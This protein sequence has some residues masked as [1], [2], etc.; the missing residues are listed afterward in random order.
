MIRDMTPQGLSVCDPT[1]IMSPLESSH[2]RVAL[3]VPTF[4]AGATWPAFTQA[5]QGQVGVDMTVWVVDSNSKDGTLGQAQSCAW[6]TLSLGERAFNHGGTRQWAIERIEADVEFVVLMTQDALLA[7]P[8][9]L[10]RLLKPFAN[11]SVGAVYGRQLPHADATLLAAQARFFNYPNSSF[12]NTFEDR[13]RLGLKAAF[14]SNSF[15]AYR[16]THFKAV[17]GFPKHVIM[18]EDMWVAARMLMAGFKVAYASEALV[19]HSHNHSFK[20]EFQRY[21]DTG[22]FHAQAPWLLENFGSVKSEGLK[23]LK[24][25]LLLAVTRSSTR[26]EPITNWV[27]GVQP[28]LEE[29]TDSA[30]AVLLKC[31]ER[32]DEQFEL[33]ASSGMKQGIKQVLM[34]LEVLIRMAIKLIAYRLGRA[35]R[36][37]PAAWV[38]RWSSHKAYWPENDR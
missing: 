13:A 1:A 6:N 12:V 5:V 11:E 28:S 30:H 29:P 38:T 33:I 9:A 4:E 16:L 34:A 35:Y 25:Q 15:A 14:C 8:D 36:S 10:C 26:G 22:V 32:F 17:G 21:F 27:Q 19:Y 37:L 2:P 23:M 7:T 31:Q 18:G 24:A 3:V 20:E